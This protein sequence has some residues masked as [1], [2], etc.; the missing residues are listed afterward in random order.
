MGTLSQ[1]LGGSGM[2]RRRVLFTRPPRP[3]EFE[4]SVKPSYYAKR[5]AF[6]WSSAV[7]HRNPPLRLD[8]LHE[9]SGNGVVLYPEGKM[10]DSIAE[11]LTLLA[12]QDKSALCDLWAR[13][14]ESTPPPQMRKD[15]MCRMIAHRMQ[16]REFGGL[17]D[18][19]SRRL[20]QLA[21]SFIANPS[22]GAVSA[23]PIKPG[24]RLVRQWKEHVYVVTVEEEGY[25][26]KGTRYE[27]LSEIARLI[28]GTRWSGPLFF[29][30][31]KVKAKP[32]KTNELRS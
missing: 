17:G 2:Q 3:V 19:A 8:C 24:T 20:R 14:F 32:R 31:K 9:E 27:S 6:P 15:L 29:G 1:H 10:P 4:K 11:Q 26:Y 18:A 21:A 30:L 12:Q 13:F 16:E 25:E 28:T 22:S 5:A 7:C 23:R